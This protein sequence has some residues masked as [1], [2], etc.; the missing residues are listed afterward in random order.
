MAIVEYLG[1]DDIQT[2]PE[3]DAVHTAHQLFG[4]GP[5]VLSAFVEDLN[6]LVDDEVSSFNQTIH[7]L[8]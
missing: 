3:F 2:Q 4:R 1:Y 5:N 7:L 6:F 8:P